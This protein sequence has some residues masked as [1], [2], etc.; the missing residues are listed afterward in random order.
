MLVK[1]SMEKKAPRSS[2]NKKHMVGH[3]K[4]SENE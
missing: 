3:I 1:E 2:L 4:I